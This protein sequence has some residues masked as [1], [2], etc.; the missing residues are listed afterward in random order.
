MT[1]P[2]DPEAQEQARL[3][4]LA[5]ELHMRPEDVAEYERD[6]AERRYEDSIVEAYDWEESRRRAAMTEAERAAEDE[7]RRGSP[8]AEGLPF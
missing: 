2:Q 1:T 3:E 4:A 5:F 8:T 6:M 7:A